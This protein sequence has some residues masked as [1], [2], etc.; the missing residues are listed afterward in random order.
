MAL[1]LTGAIFVLVHMLTDDGASQ[2]ASKDTQ[3]QVDD[4]TSGGNPEPSTDLG[5][6]SSISSTTESNDQARYG[7]DILPELSINQ[8][9]YVLL[10]GYQLLP[11]DEYP[12]WST[13]YRVA[14]KGDWNNQL[15]D[16]TFDQDSL[17]TTIERE[18][19]EAYPDVVVKD[20][21]FIHI[22]VYQFNGSQELRDY[23]DNDYKLYSRGNC[24]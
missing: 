20:G 16:A 8:A 4:D 10:D 17:F 5:T 22:R 14:F 7:E 1:T 12:C 9:D 24:S 13:S 18:T 2:P 6:A 21:H 3:L 19:K 15:L 11:S 23:Y